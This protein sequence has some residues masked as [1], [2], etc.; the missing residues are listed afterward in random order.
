[1]RVNKGNGEGGILIKMV[2]RRLRTSEAKA[3]LSVQA[4]W[5]CHD[6]I[7]AQFPNG[8]KIGLQWNRLD[9]NHP[10]LCNQ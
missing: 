5:Y 1:M 10:R 8:I 6:H 9:S 2:G 4:S 3:F 7:L